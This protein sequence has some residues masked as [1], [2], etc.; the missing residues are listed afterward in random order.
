LLLRES[1]KVIGAFLKRADLPERGLAWI[2]YMRETKDK[3]K[4]LVK[5]Y[6]PTES[7]NFSQQVRL[8]DCSIKNELDLV[9]DMLF[10]VSELSEAELRKAVAAMP[11]AQKEEIFSAYMGERMNRRHKPGRAI[12]KLHYEWEIV[13]DYG[14]FRD[15]Q[16]HRIVDAWEWQNLTVKYG[17]DVPELITEAGFEKQFRET[18]AESEKL[19]NEMMA[20]GLEEEAQ[21]ATLL[22]HKLR[23]RF[24]MNAREAFHLLELRTSPQGH[25]GYRKICQEMH[26]QLSE[27]HPRLGAAMRFVN[28]N[29]DPALTRLDAERATQLKLK[30][31]EEKE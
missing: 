28:Q 24:V 6:L 8:V 15:L 14:T 12:E 23:Y 13:A 17:Y 16:R 10:E 31:L 22:G 29:G 30:L 11:L 25:P 20:A 18:F 5:K 21:Y 27:I 1:R 9:P 19:W 7:K 4:L 3:L 26:R 2:L